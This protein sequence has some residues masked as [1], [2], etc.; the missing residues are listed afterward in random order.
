[1]KKGDIPD[2]RRSRS[3]VFVGLSCRWLL[4]CQVLAV[5]AV[6]IRGNA[7]GEVATAEVSQKDGTGFTKEVK[8]GQAR[9]GERGGIPEI[10]SPFKTPGVTVGESL[11]HRHPALVQELSTELQDAFREVEA[12]IGLYMSL[13]EADRQ[14]AL[15]R[16]V[17]AFEF[18]QLVD[19]YDIS[20][21]TTPA[22]GGRDAA[23]GAG[24]ELATAL[25]QWRKNLEQK[26]L[27]SGEGGEVKE[28]SSNDSVVEGFSRV[29]AAFSR[30]LKEAMEKGPQQGARLQ[31]LLGQLLPSA[32]ETMT[33]CVMALQG[34]ANVFTVTLLLRL[35][36]FVTL[37]K[38]IGTALTSTVKSQM[39]GT[40]APVPKRPRSSRRTP[41]SLFD[42]KTVIS[43]VLGFIAAIMVV[44]PLAPAP[45]V[46]VV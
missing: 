3:P 31:R 43:F 13:S 26:L 33:M 16:F 45:T 37:L 1:M 4:V 6:A 38:Q 25:E 18:K 27:K 21:T 19:V 41:G 24:D 32:M 22:Q 28:E 7:S 5:F 40:T 46:V 14:A 12:A 39:S 2:G 11:S 35:Q 15:S 23:G 8:S 44:V 34:R 9:E 42:K 29:A 10:P 36:R 17:E 20:P 30:A